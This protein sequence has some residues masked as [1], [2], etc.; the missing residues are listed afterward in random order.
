MAMPEAD[1]AACT[2]SELADL[3]E[4]WEALDIPGHRI[5]LIDGQLV[6]SPSA[7]VSYSIAIDKLID[8]LIDVKRDRGWLIHTNL[9][10]HVAATRE[11]LI[12]DLMIAPQDAPGFGENELL[13]GGVLLVAEVVSPSSRRQDRVAKPR[14]YAHG[15]VPLYL[16]VDQLASPAAVTLFSDPADDGYRRHELARAGQSLRLPEPFG[17]TLDVGKVIG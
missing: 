11:R 8:A 16:L 7:S 6:V 1:W 2:E 3:E 14:A 12:P 9:T 17:I 10:M 13:A 5:E 4:V 15:Q